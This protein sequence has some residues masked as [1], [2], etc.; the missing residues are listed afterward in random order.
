MALQ[1]QLIFVNFLYQNPSFEDGFDPVVATGKTN[2]CTGT[3]SPC[4]IFFSAGSN[5]MNYR[6]VESRKRFTGR[7]TCQ[8]NA[9]NS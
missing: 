8:D 1:H 3:V 7:I 5:L 6:P 2:W 9:E 4:Y